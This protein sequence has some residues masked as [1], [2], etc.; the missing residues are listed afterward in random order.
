MTEFETIFSKNKTYPSFDVEGLKFGIA[1]NIQFVM[2]QKGITQTE[3]ATKIGSSQPYVS[4]IL[5]GQ[6]NFTVETLVMISK[7][8]GTNLVIDLVGESDEI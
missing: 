6:T 3:L 2:R 4:Q 1:K 7:A 5:R 8:L